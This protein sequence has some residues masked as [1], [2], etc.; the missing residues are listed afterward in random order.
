MKNPELIFKQLL[1][2]IGEDTSREGLV[3]TPKRMAKAWKEITCGY[4]QDPADYFKTF[5]EDAEDYDQ[6]IL[7]DPIPYYSTC[8]HHLLPFFGHAYIGYIPDKTFAGISK[9]ARVVETFSKRL[10]IQER[11]TEQIASAIN[12]GVSPLGVGVI[13]RG[14]HLCMSMRGVK[15]PGVVTTTSSMKGVFLN[16]AKAR[17]E[18]LQLI[19]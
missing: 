8:E 18:F 5:S 9:F 16:D 12:E 7:L 4:D 3:E 15:S 1:H 10:Q 6:M 11:M 17:N 14:E 13:I 2:Y 19:K